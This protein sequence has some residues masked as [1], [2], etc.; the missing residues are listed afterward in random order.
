MKIKWFQSAKTW[1]I[2]IP[3]AIAL[4]ILLFVRIPHPVNTYGKSMPVRQWILETG[5]DGRVMHSVLNHETGFRDAY[6]VYQVERGEIMQFRLHS[7]LSFHHRISRG[8]TIGRIYSSE[9]DAQLAGLRGELDLAV[10][11]LNVGLTGEKQAVL[12]EYENRLALARE[13]AA[14]LQKE[15]NRIENLHEKNLIS[16][17]EYEAAK[18]R[19]S[20]ARINIFVMEAQLEAARTGEKT[21]Q[22]RLLEAQITA[23]KREIDTLEKRIRQFTLTAPFDGVL[24]TF[25]ASDTLLSVSDTSAAVVLCPVR[26][27]DRKK[28]RPGLD[29]NIRWMNSTYQARGELIS[30]KNEPQHLNNEYVLTAV[31]K[32]AD[33][34]PGCILAGSLTKCSIRTDRSRILDSLINMMND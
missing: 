27:R 3:A 19:L 16:I 31:I 6:A 13:N 4:I 11:M 28:I 17:E 2:L 30:V 20:Q 33:P 34:Q 14:H 1:V 22:I 5:T 29:V 18:N 9:T 15:F 25:Y 26:I 7:G 23:I 24:S 21:E 8:D 10:S 32:L 12:R